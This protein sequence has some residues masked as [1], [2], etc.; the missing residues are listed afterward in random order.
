MKKVISPKKAEVISEAP[1]AQE[2]PPLVSAKFKRGCP[3]CQNKTV[4]TYTDVVALRRF[5]S[6]RA[7]ILPKLRT[8]VCSKHQ[9]RVTR[10]I[11]RARHLALLPFTPQV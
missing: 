3:F 10:E 7:R 11:K 1:E 2:K 4:P 9:R 5:T 6:D 8:G